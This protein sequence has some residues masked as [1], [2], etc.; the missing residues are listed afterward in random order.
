MDKQLEKCLYKAD[1]GERIHHLTMLPE[2]WAGLACAH[3]S[4]GASRCESWDGCQCARWESLSHDLDRLLCLFL[5]KMENE[6]LT[7][8]I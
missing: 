6:V 2:L 1:L 8:T 3:S 5:L 4:W 7:V